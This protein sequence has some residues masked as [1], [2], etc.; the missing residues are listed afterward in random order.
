[1]LVISKYS[2]TKHYSVESAITWKCSSFDRG[3]KASITTPKE[4]PY[5]AYK[6][7]NRYHDH[8]PPSSIQAS[9]GNWIKL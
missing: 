9:E 1:M 8:A 4:Y 3:C 7:V 6:Y 2:Y 5:K